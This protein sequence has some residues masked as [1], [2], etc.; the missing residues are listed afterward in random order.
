MG[1]AVHDSALQGVVSD[2]R[3]AG[4]GSELSQAETDY[5]QSLTP[6]AEDVDFTDYSGEV[7]PPACEGVAPDVQM[8]C[9]VGV[10]ALPPPIS[11][12]SA[13]ARGAGRSS[14]ANNIW[15]AACYS[16]APMAAGK[17]DAEGVSSVRQLS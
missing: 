3:L 8:D 15:L 7:I 12:A 9:S 10:E 4:E 13:G 16:G 11:P 1:I 14:P 5:G 2:P 6:P 17:D